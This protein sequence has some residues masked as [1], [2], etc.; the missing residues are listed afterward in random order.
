MSTICGQAGMK[1]STGTIER[2]VHEEKIRTGY[3]S[4]NMSEAVLLKTQGSSFTVIRK[5]ELPTV[6]Q[7]AS[8]EHPESSK[9]FVH[10]AI[11][12]VKHHL[13]STESSLSLHHHTSKEKHKEGHHS[14]KTSHH[15]KHN[16]HHSAP[17]HTPSHHPFPFPDAFSRDPDPYASYDRDANPFAPKGDGSTAPWQK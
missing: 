13:S 16:H 3:S 2:D 10:K 4:P 7:I 12:Q 6:H 15:H 11:K 8:H 17:G 1:P 5:G 14:S 9:E